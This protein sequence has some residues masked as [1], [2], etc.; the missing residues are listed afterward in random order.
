MLDYNIPFALLI[1]PQ[2]G[3]VGEACIDIL[4]LIITQVTVLLQHTAR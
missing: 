4:F 1:R 2:A 3:H